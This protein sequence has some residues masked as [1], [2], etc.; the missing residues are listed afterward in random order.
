MATNA[1][2]P[3][4]PMLRGIQVTVKLRQFHLSISFLSYFFGS[5]LLPRLLSV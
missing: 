2:D 3:F 5:A 1:N 4:T